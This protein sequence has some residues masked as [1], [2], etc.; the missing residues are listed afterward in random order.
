MGRDTAEV[1][2]VVEPGRIEMV[3]MP[4]PDTG[5]DDGLL[6]V[7]T[8]GICGSDLE[9]LEADGYELPM[10]LGHEPTGRILRLGAAAQERWGVDVGDRVAV[11]SQLRCGT[12][13][14]CRG[15][16]RCTSFPGTYGTMPARHPPG[17]WGG[18]A[19]HM[20]LAP[21]ASMVRVA[22]TVSTAELAFHNALANGF[23]WAV[24]AG[25]AG[26]GTD[27]LILGA[28]PRGVGCAL[29]ALHAGARRVTVAGLAHD[30]ARLAMAQEFGV[31]RAVVVTS[32]EPDELREVTG[33]HHVVVDTTPH[34]G[35]AV[36]QAVAATATG[37]RVVLCGIKAPG[38][39]LDIDVNEIVYRRLSLI[40][41]P[42]KTERSFTAAVEALNSGLLSRARMPTA[43]YPLARTREA[44]ATLTSTDPDR[45]FH[46]RV[47][48]GAS[49]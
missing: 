17:L 27:V 37:G 10:V 35:S 13:A 16:G 40:G 25:G 44:I 11:S 41:P 23:E 3:E 21:S 12:C 2:V 45:P 26:P 9:L 33:S 38:V 8:N 4:L 1:M 7:E 5:D 22:D 20:Y 47:E 29:A 24:G 39:R 43:A 32:A 19:T 48:P 18:F 6:L 42:S 14:G 36:L 28:G 31:H 15:G 49:A 34:S 30:R 46:V